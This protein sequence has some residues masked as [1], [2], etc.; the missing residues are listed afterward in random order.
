MD[1][2]TIRK[3]EAEI[4]QLRSYLASAEAERLDLK[5]RYVELGERF[6]ALIIAEDQKRQNTVTCN[7][8]AAV[9]EKTVEALSA[10]LTE[11]ATTLNDHRKSLASLPTQLARVKTDLV[12]LAQQI[13]SE[14]QLLQTPV[15][16]RET[17]KIDFEEAIR[18]GLGFTEINITDTS[19]LSLEI[20]SAV[21][22][23][24]THATAGLREEFVKLRDETVSLRHAWLAEREESAREIDRLNKRLAMP[25]SPPL[26]MDSFE[27]DK[28]GRECQRLNDLLHSRELQLSQ[29]MESRQEQLRA[30]FSTN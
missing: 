19:T 2:D 10:K 15:K 7:D 9:A 18:T 26:V 8:R 28:L 29:L 22:A 14:R 30:S 4:R 24:I 13:R 1:K 5:R 25:V 12:E 3:K 23:K 6:E 27:V 20:A 17:E 11:A 21:N 16:L